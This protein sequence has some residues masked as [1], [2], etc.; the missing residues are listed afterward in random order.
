MS[1]K[2]ILFISDLHLEAQR[3]E[4]TQAFFSFLQEHAEQAQALY[5]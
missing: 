5:I 3:P 4:I 2:P 1:E